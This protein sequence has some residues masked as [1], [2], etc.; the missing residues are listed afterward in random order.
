M[1]RP[2]LQSTWYE[3]L[4]PVS[5]LSQPRIHQFSLEHSVSPNAEHTHPLSEYETELI[6]GEGSVQN[7]PGK[8]K[9]QITFGA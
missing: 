5:I 2:S 8:H 9:R 4:V 7:D 6:Q 3:V 1:P